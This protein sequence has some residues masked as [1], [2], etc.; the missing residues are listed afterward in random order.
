MKT[1]SSVRVVAET[2]NRRFVF[3]L[4]C[5]WRKFFSCVLSLC[6]TYI[7]GKRALVASLVT[8]LCAWGCTRA[9]VCLDGL[10]VLL[11]LFF[12]APSVISALPGHIYLVCCLRI[13]NIY[14]T[15]I[16]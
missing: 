9:Y 12:S 1:V 11:C 6:F 5:Y 14:I 7:S 15:Y 8:F 10:L 16:L 4:V 13:E 2:V 3:S